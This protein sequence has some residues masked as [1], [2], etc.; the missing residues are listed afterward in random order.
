MP[1]RRDDPWG[2]PPSKPL[3]ASGGIATTRQRGAM[4][5][6]WWSKRFID[7]LESFALGGRMQ[8]G[9]RYARAGQV[10]SID[11]TP[12]RI[13]AK[14][15]GSRRTPYEVTVA[16]P[17]PVIEQWTRIEDA[18][19]ARVGFVA[20]LLEGD[21]PHDLESVFT[22]AGA[23][24]FPRT[25][26]ELDA[27]CTCPDWESPCKHLGATLYVFAD[28]LDRD[29]WLLLAWRGRTHDELLDVLTPG[30]AGTAAATGS[31]LPVWWPLTPGSLPSPAVGDAL[32]VPFDVPAPEPPDPPAA[33]L[34]RL[35]GDLEPR[36]GEDGIAE[37]IAPAYAVFVST[38]ESARSA[39]IAEA[40]P[41]PSVGARPRGTARR[42]RGA[43]TP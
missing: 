17:P 12:G 41:A 5:E 39:A 36:A 35:A 34:R 26:G 7:V 14:V 24:L 16:F 13:V 20:H 18:M 33:V 30:A 28:Q 2:Y 10:L 23:P 4:A 15:Q 43:P 3:P 37:R 38:D 27:D 40:E 8:R 6:T 32:L 25:W 9:R 11:V 31:V 29:P 22:D 42:Q 1:R 21:V 19:R